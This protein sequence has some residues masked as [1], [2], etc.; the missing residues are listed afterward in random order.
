MP[1]WRRVRHTPPPHGAE[2]A[3]PAG[4]PG[5][6]AGQ[7]YIRDAERRSLRRLLQRR[8]NL[9]YDLAQAELALQ[10]ENPWTERIAQLDAAIAQAEADLAALRPA[11]AT[12]PRVQL[13]A[14]PIAVE[15]VRPAEPAA[16]TLRAGEVTLRYQEEIDWAERG[17]QVAL[18]QLARVAGDVAPLVPADLEASTRAALADHL[19]Q[20]FSIVAEEALERAAAG[21]PPPAYTL[22]DL[23]RPCPT[24][25]G[26]QDPKGR[27]AACAE[28]ERQRQRIR[29]GLERLRAERDEQRQEME[30]YRERLPVIRRQLAETEAD[31]AKLRAKGVE[32]A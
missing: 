12:V 29:A 15:D 25:G 32:P 17:H 2:P 4:T 9:A 20:G 24:C 11:P 14:T 27:C 26:W 7:P 18:P 5:D 6:D 23:T 19:R 3:A 16:V 30:R 13:P 22:A 8:S 10:P 1:W 31:I 28:L 21:E